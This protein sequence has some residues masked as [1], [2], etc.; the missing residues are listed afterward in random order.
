MKKI[1][2]LCK[3]LQKLTL[4]GFRVLGRCDAGGLVGFEQ[5]KGRQLRK[6]E[7]QGTIGEALLKSDRFLTGYWLEKPELVRWDGVS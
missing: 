4:R 2:N 7:P 3:G 6:N 1:W 5:L